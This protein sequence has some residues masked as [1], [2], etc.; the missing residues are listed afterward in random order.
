M[1]YAGVAARRADAP[2]PRGAGGGRVCPDRER[3][4]AAASFPAASSS[5][6][7]SPAR[8]S[9]TRRIM[10]AD[11]PTGNLDTRTSLEVMEIFQRLNREQ[12]I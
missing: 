2:G 7:P 5:A 6:S 8:W 11:E 10:L 9:T 12:A 4:H 3:S 1:L